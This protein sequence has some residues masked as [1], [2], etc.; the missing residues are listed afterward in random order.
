[1]RFLRTSSHYLSRAGWLV[2]GE[3]NERGS[4][5]SHVD[6]VLLMGETLTA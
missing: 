6:R 1:V 4:G 2:T 5:G 3:F